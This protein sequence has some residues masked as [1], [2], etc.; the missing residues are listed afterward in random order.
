[1]KTGYSEVVFGNLLRACGFKREDLFISNRLWFEFFPDE[2]L[3]AEVDGSLARIGIDYFDL[4][5]CFSPP[6]HLSASELVGQLA[7][8]IATGKVRYWAPGNWPVE[9]IAECC[10][11]AKN[12]G[13]PL[14]T[15]AMLRY[16]LLERSFAENEA[17]EAVCREHNIGMVVSF[18]L[19]GGLLTGKYNLEQ[20]PVTVRGNSAQMEALRD[21]AAL[22]S[23][24]R[25]VELA[26]D[27]GHSPAALALAF[28]LRHPQVS[29]LLFGVTSVSQL[30]E[31]LGVLEVVPSLNDELLARLE[32]IFPRQAG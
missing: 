4:V 27:I 17:M 30:E 8:L 14:P 6:T 23:T 5:F 1:M 9:L 12:T 2:S 10:S 7:D 16:S 28:C 24:A 11:V 13:A 25:L 3:E 19:H 32:A 20:E 31:N 18:A 26:A 15:A 21:N 29:S 22:A